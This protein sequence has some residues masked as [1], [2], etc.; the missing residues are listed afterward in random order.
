MWCYIVYALGLLAQQTVYALN[1][2][3]H[4][5]FNYLIIMNL[6][7]TNTSNHTL[8]HSIL[9]SCTE[10]TRW[11]NQPTI[12][13]D[14][15][16]TLLS[17]NDSIATLLQSHNLTYS[18][19]Y[20]N[21]SVLQPID[22][23]LLYN[24]STNNVYNTS[25]VSEHFSTLNQSTIANLTYVVPSASDYANDTI[26]YLYNFLLSNSLLQ[27][28]TSITTLVN[29]VTSSNHTQFM[30]NIICGNKIPRNKTYSIEMQP[31][32][33]IKSIQDNFNVSHS[34]I[35]VLNITDE[36]D[37]ILA[38][39]D[40]PITVTNDST[41]RYGTGDSGSTPL[42]TQFMYVVFEDKS[43]DA[44][45]NNPY[46]NSIAQNGTLFTDWHGVT[47]PSQ[48]NYIAWSGGSTFG[49]LDSVNDYDI[50]YD[51]LVDLFDHSNITWRVYADGYIPLNNGDCDTSAL[52]GIPDTSSNA[53]YNSTTYYRKHNPFMSYTDISNNITRCQNIVNS[54]QF[55]IDL[56]NGTLPQYIYYVPDQANDGRDPDGESGIDAG[57]NF[58]GRWIY[59][60]LQHWY[61]QPNFHNISL[62]L[63][64]DENDSVT[65]SNH[66]YAVLL[67][68]G[69]QPGK[70]VNTTYNHYS[71]L[72]TLEL[73]WNLGTLGRHDVNATDFIKDIVV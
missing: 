56:Q 26:Q 57:I 58:A 22:T 46:W 54:A 73:N 12:T 44:A 5:V 67:N 9:P 42:M 41:V 10:F 48:P 33:I 23:Y 8:Y 14:T 1:N 65:P 60:K 64:F 47:H 28:N 51:N 34:N 55:E 21:S 61:T 52:I 39:V 50:P 71:L 32:S 4:D 24:L 69:A 7:Y 68:R 62:M 36:I 3:G 11:M 31:L 72:K 27:S 45:M 35:D 63:A 17:H 49:I 20:T 13:N 19:V 40:P 29:F 70:L 37:N 59:N 16:N 30:P 25:S 38:V 18:F 43:Y 15:V 53:T 2:N 66:V 6:P